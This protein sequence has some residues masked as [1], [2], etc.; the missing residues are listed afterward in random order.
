MEAAVYDN[1]NQA[2]Q[3]L[4]FL[5]ANQLYDSCAVQGCCVKKNKV[6]ET[7]KDRHNNPI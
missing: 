3:A 1:C 4:E 7:S 2:F 5:F 6:D